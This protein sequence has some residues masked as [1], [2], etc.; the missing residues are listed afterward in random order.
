L[1]CEI[2]AKV[3]FQEV[4][5]ER[6]MLEPTRCTGC[7]VCEAICS[8]VHE[9]EFNPTKSRI[10][11]VRTI[12]NSILYSIPV[13]CL[14]CEEASCAAVCP[15]HVITRNSKGALIVDGEKCIGCKLCEIACP[16]GA[17]VVNAQNGVSLKCDLCEGQEGPQCVQYCYA[18][19]LR[20]LPS[21]KV[22][23]AKARSKAEKFLEMERKEA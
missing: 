17:I 18:Q 14:Q 11:V 20:F 1:K 3:I 10:K 19:A 21:E 8:L 7:R 13:F 6:I 12:E 15:V 5:M 2:P 16:V 4:N 9:G 23:L 22:G